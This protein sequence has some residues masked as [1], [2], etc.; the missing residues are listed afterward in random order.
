MTDAKGVKAELVFKPETD[1]AVIRS[2]V[3]DFEFL[4]SQLCVCGERTFQ[5]CCLDTYHVHATDAE[6]EYLEL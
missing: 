5:D 4:I 2:V 3:R 6:G 1:E